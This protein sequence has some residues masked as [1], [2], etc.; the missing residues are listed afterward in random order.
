MGVLLLLLQT[1]LMQRDLCRAHRKASLTNEFLRRW[2]HQANVAQRAAPSRAVLS[3]RLTRTGIASSSGRKRP[4]A[5]NAFMK[6]VHHVLFERIARMV[7]G[8]CD[9]H[10][11]PLGFRIPPSPMLSWKCLRTSSGTR[12]LASSGQR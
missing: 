2:G 6:A 10:L 3:L 1:M 11:T 7:G 4:F 12:N 8:H 5:V 9:A